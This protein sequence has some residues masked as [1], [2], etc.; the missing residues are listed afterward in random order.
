LAERGFTRLVGVIEKVQVNNWVLDLPLE[1]LDVFAM[2]HTASLLS[3][4]QYGPFRLMLRCVEARFRTKYCR[5][6][7]EWVQQLPAH[8]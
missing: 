6:E 8:W 2:N 5:Q 7:P 1:R 4:S 3:R